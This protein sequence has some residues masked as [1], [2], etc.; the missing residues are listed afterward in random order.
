[1]QG[2]QIPGTT[3]LEKLVS[4]HPISKIAK[5]EASMERKETAEQFC[6]AQRRE[7]V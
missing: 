6:P 5:S 3:E 2:Q 4:I 1:M 7:F